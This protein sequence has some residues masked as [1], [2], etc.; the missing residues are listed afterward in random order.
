LVGIPTAVGQDSENVTVEVGECVDLELPE[1]RFACYEAQVE[2]ALRADD[3]AVTAEP[4]EHPP[5]TQQAEAREN[6]SGGDRT[7]QPPRGQSPQEFVG[8]VTAL[9]ETVP[10]SFVITLD[11]GQVW[12]QMRPKW[13]PLRPGQRVRIYSTNWGNAFRL[14]AEELNSFIQVERVR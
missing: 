14:T 9:R 6:A 3:Q 2:A 12:R 8:T 5:V 10:N 11:N 7:T 13:Y 4:H 1:E